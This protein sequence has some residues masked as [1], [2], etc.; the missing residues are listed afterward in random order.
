[1]D[2]ATAIKKAK[3]G[4][5]ISSTGLPAISKV[6]ELILSFLPSAYTGIDHGRDLHKL[7]LKT[8]STKSNFQ[9]SGALQ[10]PFLKVNSQV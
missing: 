7:L 6:A 3:H 10:G 5:T 1:M 4:R 9:G 8:L 2:K